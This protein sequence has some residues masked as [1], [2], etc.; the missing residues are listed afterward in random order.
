M[1][2]KSVLLWACAVFLTVGVF[3]FALSIP[4]TL[5]QGSEDVSLKALEILEHNCGSSGCHG[6]P[7]PTSFNVRN[8]ASLLSAGVV[9]SGD[10]EGSEL[11]RRVE[12]GAMPLGGYKGRPGTKLPAEDIQALR[13]WI[14]AG[15]PA[16][17]TP[18]RCVRRRFIPESQVLAAINRDL[19]STPRGDRPYLRYYSLASLW[20]SADVE[21]TELDLCGLA[22]SK[23]VNHLSWERQI[24]PPKQLGPENTVLRIDLRDYGWTT[25]TWGRIVASYPYGLVARNLREEIDRIQA[26]SGVRL[27]YIR[28]DWFIASASVPPLYHSILQLPPTLKELEDLL[29]VDAEFGVQQNLAAR[30]GLRNS[31]VSRNNRAMERHGTIYGAYWKSFDFAGNNPEQN[32]F[33]NPLDLHADGGEVI[34]HLPNGLQAYFIADRQG[35]RIDE[36]PVNIVRDKT[37]PEDPVVRNGR[38][39]IGC[40]LNGLNTFQDGVRPTLEARAQALF[41]LEQALALYPGPRELDRLL[42]LDNRRFSDALRQVGDT[43][44]GNGS[45]PIN[46]VARK[47]EAALSVSQAASDLFVEDPERLQKLIKASIELQ[48]QGFD[49]LLGPKGGVKRDSWE[50]GFGMVAGYAGI[51]EF[52]SPTEPLRFSK[53]H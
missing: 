31:G 15:G 45:E 46:R 11:I 52:V 50:Q 53:R 36:A 47:Y 41:N 4:R 43:V 26:L 21:G 32:I 27:P 25:E 42:E 49:Q 17:G 35:R 20:N 29:R 8:P 28:A 40:H 7:S 30:F 16:L 44:A 6:G 3:P 24:T 12:T 10:A 48:V 5:A 13:R 38:S 14:D 2:S 51:G 19:E 18:A 23:L 9:L 1:L 37:N 22:L 33:R 39:C 34:F